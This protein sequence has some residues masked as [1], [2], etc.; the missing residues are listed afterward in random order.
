MEP[1]RAEIQALNEVI[2][3]QQRYI[4]ELHKKHGRQLQQIPSS[5]LGAGNVHRGGRQTAA[6]RDTCKESSKLISFFC[7]DSIMANVQTAL[8]CL[9]MATWPAGCT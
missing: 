7:P 4:Q 2:D 8:M 1:L 3:D 5:L 6:P 9:P